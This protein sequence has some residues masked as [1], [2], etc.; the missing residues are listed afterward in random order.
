MR[1]SRIRAVGFRGIRGEL[2]VA[3]PA[4]FLVVTGR[5]GTGKT[6]LCD[7]I[8][9]A[10]TG[11]IER[12]VG[13]SEVRES[14]D[15]YIWW[16]GDGSADDHFVELELIRETGETVHVRRDRKSSSITALDASVLCDVELAPEA[17]ATQMCRTSIIRDDTIASF[18]LELAESDRFQFV[19]AAMGS[20][21]VD[22]YNDV[23]R[24]VGKRLESQL[25]DAVAA[26]NNRRDRAVA[27]REEISTAKASLASREDVVRAENDLQSILAAAPGATAELLPRAR[28]MVIALRQRENVLVGLTRML[29]ERSKT[30][31]LVGHDFAA[32]LDAARAAMAELELKVATAEGAA[33][34]AA[35]ERDGLA[36]AQP[37]L[38]AMASLAQDAEVVGLVD[39]A[40]PTCRSA[41]SHDQLRA[42]I[43]QL[44]RK[45]EEQSLAIATATDRLAIADGEVM[46]LRRELAQA[47]SAMS[48]TE[49]DAEQFATGTRKLS[50]LAHAAGFGANSA[51][52][53]D[54]V[55]QDLSDVRQQTVVLQRAIATLEAHGETSRIAELERSLDAVQRDCDD[56][57]ATQTRLENARERVKAVSKAVRRVAGEVLED[58][59]AGLAPLL[60]DLYLRIRPHS[61]WRDVQY[62]LRG[63]VRRLLSLRVGP[64]LN[65]RFMFSSGQRRAT[66]LAFLLSVHLSRTWCRLN[67]LVLDDPIQHIDDF[68]ALH[69]VEVLSAIRQTG[70]QIVCS[71]EDPDLARL[72]G[73]RLRS[74]FEQEGAIV[75][76]SRDV[77]GQTVATAHP[78]PPM[79]RV[80]TLASKTA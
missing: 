52:T 16:R 73:R 26:Y 19:Q 48:R 70:R 2:D 55:D 35:R 45:V 58:K 34:E 38:A 64:D 22:K 60:S 13:K 49:A 4:G 21:D 11:T 75:E 72:L 77:A 56:L 24:E 61:D 74:D 12:Y 65:P 68:R 51:V 46:R 43:E 9:Y 28:E 1:L 59:L 10:L 27:L 71:V 57:G 18:S 79:R 23:L 5:N 78:V 3:V 50:A 40:C 80:L 69:F 14:L 63:D 32:R 30:L 20:T 67:T 53:R 44:R 29:D 8:E 36:A 54:I 62:H 66:G 31:E 17:W 47:R 7:A 41:V 76:L 15:E 25:S 37:L 6:T 33:G 42:G 39:D